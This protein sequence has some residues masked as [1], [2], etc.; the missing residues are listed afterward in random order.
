MRLLRVSAAVV[1]V[2]LLIP[3]AV[4]GITADIVGKVCERMFSRGR[5]L[6]EEW[7]R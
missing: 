4:I 3:V 1:L 5:A 2:I 7:L 6:A